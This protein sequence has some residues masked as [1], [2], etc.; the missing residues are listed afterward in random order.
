[1]L[2]DPLG[3]HQSD[4]ELLADFSDFM[5]GDTVFEDGCPSPPDPAFRDR[6]RRRIW[7]T[8]VH[9]NLRDTHETH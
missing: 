6:L 4:S 2:D 3:V 8:H 7:R 9:A 1:M 5:Q